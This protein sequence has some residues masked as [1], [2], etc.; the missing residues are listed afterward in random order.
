MGSDNNG[1][2]Q[3]FLR[4]QKLIIRGPLGRVTVTNSEYCWATSPDVCDASCYGVS[5]TGIVLVDIAL[6]LYAVVLPGIALARVWF[7]SEEV[8][9]TLAL[10]TAVGVFTLPLLAFAIAVL[11]R[12]HIS[13]MF[14]LLQGTVVLV[15][16]GGILWRRKRTKQDAIAGS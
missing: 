10:G 12:T 14:I 13:P 3:A 16:A 6:F 4:G 9:L 15:I 5:V 8:L 1:Y 11:L 2:T 7:G